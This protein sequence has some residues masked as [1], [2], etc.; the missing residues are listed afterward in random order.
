MGVGPLCRLFG[1]FRQAYYKKEW[2]LSD[3]EQM[4]LVVL[5]LISIVAENFQVLAFT[6]FISASISRCERIILKWAGIG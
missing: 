2:H 5:E 3:A 1:K 4:E 6:N